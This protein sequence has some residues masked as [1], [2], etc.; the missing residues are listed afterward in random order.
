M[1]TVPFLAGIASIGLMFVL[2]ARTFASA[3]FGFVAAGVLALT[4]LLWLQGH[5]APASLYPLPFVIGWLLAVDHF[6]DTRAPWWAAVAGGFLGV[7]VY[8]SHAASVMMPLYLLLTIA[9]VAPARAIPPRQ[10]SVFVAAFLVTVSPFAMSLVRHPDDFKNTVT[11]FHLYDASRFTLLQGVHEMVSWVGLTARS[12]VYYDYFN[13][14]FLF[15]TGRVLLLPLVVLLPAG[16]YRILTD[17]STPLAR[18]SLAGFLAA[19]FAASL[20]AEPPTPGR[21]LFITPFAAMVST[22]GVQHLLSLRTWLVA[23]F[24]RL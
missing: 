23:S 20:T 2:G 18:L 6:R 19:P 15:L 3:R 24:S 17:E 13:P 14:A 10:L 1:R 21:I 4:P 5:N 22:Y 16:L 11:A 7:G 12:E 9:V 8:S